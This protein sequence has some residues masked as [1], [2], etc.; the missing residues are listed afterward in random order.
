MVTQ[1]HKVIWFPGYI[2]LPI[3]HSNQTSL[4]VIQPSIFR[5]YVH[6]GQKIN[7]K[8]SETFMYQGITDLQLMFVFL[9]SPQYF[10]NLNLN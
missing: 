4:C 6:I 9:K 7:A 5:N 8:S 10:L 1:G 3:P 2:N